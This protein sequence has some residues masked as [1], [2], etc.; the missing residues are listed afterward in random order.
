MN[1]LAV[2]TSEI[3]FKQ[4]YES[5]LSYFPEEEIKYLPWFHS[6]FIGSIVGCFLDPLINIAGNRE[7]LTKKLHQQGFYICAVFAKDYM[8]KVQQKRFLPN[9]L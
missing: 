6:L 4:L 3:E 8:G 5:A 7:V 9:H 1:L 2:Y